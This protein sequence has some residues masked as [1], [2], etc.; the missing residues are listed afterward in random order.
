MAIA[1]NS[2]NAGNRTNSGTS[3][4]WTHTGISS[5]SNTIVFIGA[6]SGDSTSSNLTCTVDGS[7][8]T[9]VN[10]GVSPPT[11]GGTVKLFYVLNVS[12]ASVSISVNTSGSATNLEGVSAA[13]NGVVGGIDNQTTNSGTSNSFTTSLTTVQDNCWTGLVAIQQGDTLSAGTGSNKVQA[14]TGQLTWFDSNAVIHP[15]ASY[16][17]TVT[18]SFSGDHWGVVMASF[19][20]TSE[21]GPTNLKTW[22]GITNTNIKNLYDVVAIG[23]VKK[24]NELT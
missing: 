15:A 21:T 4:T 2:S 5:P 10:T 9:A 17:M 14:N 19:S 20:P 22:N 23:A 1:F 13:Y 16:S 7:P 18:S 8:A 6:F 24:W 11:S 12:A 3:I